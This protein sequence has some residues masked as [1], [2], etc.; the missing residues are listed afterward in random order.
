M[1][2]PFRVLLAQP[3]WP[4]SQ[5]WGR[6][7][8][9]AG[10]NT[11]AY[12]MA[13]IAA[14]AEKAGFSVNVLDTQVEETSETEF[15][16]F[17]EEGRFDVIG[18]PCYTGSALWVFDTAK[19]CKRILPDAVVILGNIHPTIMP[20][21]TL[22]ECP[23][24]DAV[25]IG[26]GELTFLDLL[27]HYRDGK[28]SLKD[29]LGIAFR[30]RNEVVVNAPR[31]LIQDLNTLPMPAYHLFPME[32]YVF[33]AYWVRRYPTFGITINRGCPFRCAFCN[34]NTIHGRK[35][36]H[37]SHERI[38]EEIKFLQTRY[39][40]RGFVFQDST[41]TTDKTWVHSFCEELIR[42][43][44][45]IPWS[46]LS[47]VDTLDEEILRVMKQAGCWCIS[48]GI[49]SG[50]Q[51]SLDLIMK[52][53]TVEQNCKAVELALKTGIYI[54][55]T[56]IIG[57]PGEDE[58]D[59][60][61]TIA[62]AKDLATHF[63]LFFLPVPFPGTRLWELC[64][65]D[66]GLRETASWDDFRATDFSNPVYVNPILGKEKMIGLYRK[67]MQSYYCHPK[68]IARNLLSIR[69]LD[70]IRRYWYGVLALIGI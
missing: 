34:A 32:K 15:I 26:E 24:V 13:S 46:C 16:R 23:E 39:G 64:K 36:R 31:P 38:I 63:A 42:Q 43:N 55:G 10:N 33:V 70:D 49:E 3:L 67:A 56:Y 68:V 66:G 21:E 27:H 20:Q 7:A 58:S 40:A 14:V 35:L 8:K 25:V 61:R 6:F 48:L 29:I 37:K 69:S 60:N 54:G 4:K 53:T 11:F 30:D 59:V 2:K 62:F 9:G 17:L 57:L 45:H 28:S 44:I 41:F 50:N 5:Q 1:D 51:K 22:Q 19:L 65:K 12:G 52:G 47:R 18:M